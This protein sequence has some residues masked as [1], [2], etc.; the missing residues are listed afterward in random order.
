MIKNL[1][2]IIFIFL[3]SLLNA[4]SFDSKGN[5]FLR[6]DYAVFFE[7]AYQTYPEIP[8]GYLEAFAYHN[9]RIHHNTKNNTTESCSQMPFYFGVMGL[10]EN[11]KNVF[12]NN[13]ET[14]SNSSGY[15]KKQIN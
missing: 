12:K 15:S 3:I 8:R 5:L 6:N 7:E 13:L 14:V 1:H 9:T 10:I 2:F 11:G 4:Q